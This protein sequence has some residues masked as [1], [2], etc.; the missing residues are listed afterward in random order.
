MVNLGG[1]SNLLPSFGSW[2]SLM[3]TFIWGLVLIGVIVFGAIYARN[4]IK[5]KYFGIIFKRRQSTDGMPESVM[6]YGKAG[7]FISKKK[8]RTIFRVKFGAMP[9]QVV[10]LSKL[11]DPKYMIGNMVAYEQLNKDNL[12]QCKINVDWNGGLN[13]KPVEDDLKHAA[14]LDFYDKEQVLST[15]KL[16]P[17]T[18]GFVVLGVILTAGII[19]FYFLS[20][21]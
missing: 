21:D 3:S 15:S 10:E 2:Q 19:V 1:V 20:K 4:K 5:Y 11:P 18:V 6:N 13:L 12:V 7:Y 14:Y 8:R 16:T 17:L 9:W